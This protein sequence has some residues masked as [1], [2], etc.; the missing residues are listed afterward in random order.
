MWPFKRKKTQKSLTH[1]IACPHC[2]SRATFP[3]VPYG[4]DASVSVKT[5]RGSRYVERRCKDCG[6]SF[7][8]DIPDSDNSSVYID[9]DID[10][11]EELRLADE[12]L[13]RLTDEEGAHRFP[14]H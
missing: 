12:D 14:S 7:Y 13:K 8:A 4:N 10:D 6:R 9:E 3:S 11:T 2:G 1:G 5:W